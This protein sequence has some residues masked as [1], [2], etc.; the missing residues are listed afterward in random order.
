MK[1]N[2]IIFAIGLSL[3]T[4]FSGCVK[5][6]VND[7]TK[8]YLTTDAAYLLTDGQKNLVDIMT[9]ANVNRNVFRLLSQ[10]WTQTTYTDES[11]YILTNRDIP[12]NFWTAIYRDAIKAFVEAKKIVA[13]D[14]K[15]TD[16]KLRAEQI[17]LLDVM[18]QYSYYVLTSTFGDIPY[19]QAL[20]INNTQPKYDASAVVLDSIVAKLDRDI[21]ALAYNSGEAFPAADLIYGGNSDNWI[22]FANGLK[23]KIGILMYDAN[24]SKAKTI[25]ESAAPNTFTSASEN[26]KF[27]YL[28]SPPNTNP[29]WEDLVQSGR[30]DFVVTETLIANMD[31][32]Y[33]GAGNIDPRL[34][35]YAELSVDTPIYIGGIYGSS[36]SDGGDVSFP[37]AIITDPTFAGVLMSYSE[38]QLLLAE[39][40]SYG[41]NVGGTAQ[42]LYKNSILESMSEWGISS[43][44]AA[45][46]YAIPAVDYNAGTNTVKE[47]IAMQ[48]WLSLYNRGFEAWTQWRKF[49]YPTFTPPPGKTLA[50]VPVRY[51]YPVAEQNLNTANYNTAAAAL[52]GDTKT[53]KL[54]WDKF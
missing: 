25:I 54:F 44:D 40:A 48:N 43:T 26:A 27:T 49:D 15:I 10:H 9:S 16:T 14:K 38:I 46:Y 5:T 50:D 18:E 1:N 28:S 29:I 36:N 32:T 53:T 42:D 24:P 6:S 21:T 22:K 20:D 37:G 30:N 52:G 2:K 41:M 4:I 3:L 19:N 35:L 12:D 17:A 34:P 7:D 51:T 13:I 45:N 23:V 39:A 47:K 8:S 33:L 11:R 31:S